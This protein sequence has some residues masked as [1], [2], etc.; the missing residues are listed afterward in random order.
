MQPLNPILRVE[1]DGFVSVYEVNGTGQRRLVKREAVKQSLA[2][3]AR[4]GR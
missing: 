2:S 1:K 3:A 4:M